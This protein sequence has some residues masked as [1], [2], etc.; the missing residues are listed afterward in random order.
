[1][2]HIERKPIQW[3]WDGRIPLGKL[4]ILD[5]E[6]G[7]GKST[8]VCELAACI[9]TG[10]LLPGQTVPLIGD[11]LLLNAED[12][13]DDTIKPRLE[14]AGADLAR[15]HVH[16]GLLKIPD[17]LH[18]L[19]EIVNAYPIRLIVIDP[20][21]AYLARNSHKDQD[22]RQ[23][24]TPLAQ[25]AQRHNIAVLI[26]R[27]LNK[28]TDASALHRGGGSIGIIGAARSGLLLGVDPDDPQ[29]RI[30]AVS[31]SNL[32]KTPNS[33]RLAL[34][35][36]GDT[37]KIEWLG[38]CNQDA[39]QLV[40]P[41]ESEEARSALADA[42]D[43]LRQALSDG[44]LQQSKLLELANAEGIKP[45]TLKRAKRQLAI[46]SIKL[47]GQRGEW[48]WALPGS[49]ASPVASLAPVAPLTQARD[50]G[51]P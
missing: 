44:A 10:R 17:D 5:G 49:T 31:K 2:S 39:D 6:P 41:R 22:V 8:L 27:H 33:L 14:A 35:S 9:S 7:L 29:K 18:K 38:E 1:M 43:F 51:T 32:A 36:V 48:T 28:R 23:A 15:V 45:G 42:G 24:L 11:V 50:G 47:P 16:T 4:T 12:A 21:M 34:C 19:E 46:A 20:L 13:A 25:L 40:G 26:V 3:L 30:L 37:A